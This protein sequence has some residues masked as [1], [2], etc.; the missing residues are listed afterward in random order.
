MQHWE[1]QEYIPLYAV[2]GLSAE[3][4]SRLAQ[5]LDVCS[6]C[7][8]LLSEYRFVAD[9]LLENVPAQTAPAR[10]GVRLQNLAEADARKSSTGKETEKRPPFWGERISFPRWALALVLGAL[11]LLVGA[12]GTLALQA[13]RSDSTPQQ[14]M[15]LLSARNIRFVD[16]TPEAAATNTGGFLCTAQNNSTGLLWLYNLEPLDRDKVYQVWLRVN[17]TRESGGTFRSNYDGRAVAVVQASR[18]LNE[19]KEIGITI[20]PV[21]GSR[22]PTTP[23]VLRGKLD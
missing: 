12:T 8:A 1:I 14:V 16:L 6:G 17:G 5:H 9:E 20:E 21:S 11:L 18:P 4:S 19:Y 15:Q 13:T 10:L 7:R 22:Q 3:E 23:G 2:G